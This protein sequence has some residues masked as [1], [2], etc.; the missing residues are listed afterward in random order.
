MTRHSFARGRWVVA[1]QSALLG[2]GLALSGAQPALAQTLPESSAT[3]LRWRLIGP[4]RGGRAVAVA[5]IPGDPTTFYFGAVAG[6]VW[7]TVNAG[8]TWEPLF[9]HEPTGSI[10][11]LAVAA[12]DPNVIYV[13]TGEADLR[14]DITFGAGVYRSTDGGTHWAYLGLDDTRH[15]GRI[16][17]DPR[18]PSVVLVAALGHAYG[19]NPERGVFRSSDGG[20]T[21]DHVLYKDAETGAIDL[22]ADPGDPAVVY[23]ALWQARRPPWS[24]YPPDEGPGSGLYRS[25]DGGKTWAP[26]GGRG[27][28]AGPHGRIGLAAARGPEGSRVYALVGAREGAGLYRSDDGGASWRLAGADPR[29]TSRNWYFCRVTVDPRNADVVYVPNVALLRSTDG[30]ATFEAIKGAPGGDDYHELWVDPQVSTHMIVGSDQ[31]ASV[32][33]DAGRTWSS[34]YN[35]PT[36]Q[37]Y[38]VATDDEFPYRVYGAQQDA[39]TAATLSRSDYGE[40]TFRDWQPVGAGE[41][42]YIAPDPMHPGVVYGGDTYGGVY[43]FDRATGQSQDIAPWPLSAFGQPMPERKY[44]FTWTSPLV[45]DRLDP[46]TLYLGAHL[47]L[48]TR[49]GGLHWDVISA[50]LTGAESPAQSHSG[51]VTVTNAA[52]RGYGV[53]Y[54]IAPSPLRPGLIWVGTDNGLIHLTTD[55]GRHWRNVTPAGLAPWSKISLI[56]ASP[57]D[58]GAAY[59]AV[60]R[61]RLDDLAPYIY[62]THDYGQHWTALGRGIAP[63]AYVHVVRADPARPGLLYAGTELGVYVS[64]DDGDDWQP[65]QLNLPTV[66]V[67]D[68][69]VHDHDLVAA[70]HG[71]AFWVLDDLTP[72]EQF[73]DV[74]ARSSA[75]LFRPAPA[76]RIRRSENRDTPLPP[77]EPHGTNPPAGAIIDYY[78]GT[79]P[80]GPIALEVRD[81]RGN[82]VRRVSSE[83]RPGVPGEPPQI[84]REWLP[85][86]EPLTRH[87]GLNRFVWNLRYPQPPADRYGYS[88]AAIA[89][90]GTVEE[91]EGPLV[92]P[93][94]YRVT[95]RVADQTYVQPLQVGLDPRVH[96]TATALADQLQLALEIWNAIAQERALHRAVEA[97][98]HELHDLAAHDLD[99]ETRP[100]VAALEQETQRLARASRAADLHRLETVVTSADR[101]PTAQSRLAFG[102]LTS[103]LA[104]A[105]TQ[106]QELVSHAVASLNARLAERGLTPLRPALEPAEHV[107]IPGAAR[108]P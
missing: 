32:S 11:A 91:P 94:E 86:P 96:V 54:T 19:S 53:I 28:P 6:G 9:D 22:A 3:A 80:T 60:D 21:W 78:L 65:L 55:A 31:G 75:H 97:L 62:R 85:R 41:S 79:V 29:I 82:V 68:L 47:L 98:A 25:A 4:F 8:L 13:G 92:L 42:G 57:L 107:E 77:E 106:W 7:K 81:A 27:L 67:R 17:V 24:Q 38:H 58:S 56:E 93:G 76:I 64:F 100:A 84:A 104:A 20:R 34:W 46:Q 61:H 87:A 48:R 15:I 30:G 49:D 2:V 102:E 18:N 1:A 108:G 23:A 40:I 5:G 99:A 101:A 90:Q 83:E 14:S 63:H 16:L 103:R 89:G 51:P 44:R 72:L 10:G 36:A 73:S 66:S 59:A 12:S 45:F 33:L 37:F 52:A 71:R 95:L 35:Q 74:V 70:T 26:V 69:A 39:G 50:D 105:R 88:M 43:R